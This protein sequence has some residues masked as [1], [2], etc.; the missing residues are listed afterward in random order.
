MSYRKI[1]LWGRKAYKKA[2]WKKSIERAYNRFMKSFD[3][4]NK[5][6]GIYNDE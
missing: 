4:D 5:G 2:R 6:K 3:K 1:P